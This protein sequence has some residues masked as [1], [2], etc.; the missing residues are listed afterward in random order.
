M[1]KQD[2]DNLS[3]CSDSLGKRHEFRSLPQTPNTGSSINRYFV[4]SYSSVYTHLYGELII[5]WQCFWMASF[6]LHFVLT[7][8]SL[9]SLPPRPVLRAR[10]WAV[11]TGGEAVSLW[12]CFCWEAH[13]LWAL[14]GR[15]SS[16][17]RATSRVRSFTPAPEYKHPLRSRIHLHWKT[18]SRRQKRL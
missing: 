8:R 9:R 2:T 13:F 18:T 17:L 12:S 1:I 11:Q 6:K 7:G 3:N 5:P 15:A 14:P 16:L 10:P 4:N